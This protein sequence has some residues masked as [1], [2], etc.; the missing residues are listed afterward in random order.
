MDDPTTAKLEAESFLR[1]I[2]VESPTRKTRK[3]CHEDATARYG[4]I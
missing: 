1:Y 2:L 4:I 3:C